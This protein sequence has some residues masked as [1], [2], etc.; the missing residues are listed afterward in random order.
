MEYAVTEK[1]AQPRILHG[2][3]VS[4]CRLPRQGLV[5]ATQY[6]PLL[7]PN[8]AILCPV[9]PGIIAYAMGEARPGH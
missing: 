7:V 9:M 8:A 2:P 3:Q 1:A 6:R 5:A 4:F